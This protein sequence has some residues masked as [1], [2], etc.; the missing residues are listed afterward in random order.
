MFV[1]FLILAVL[2]A[3]MPP[4]DLTVQAQSSEQ[5]TEDISPTQT[6]ENQVFLPFV[7]RGGTS[8]PSA[9]QF[10][11]TA[12]TDGLTI[13]GT[14]FFAVQP[15]AGETISSVSFQAGDIDLG[16]DNTP[17]D[18]FRVFVDASTLPAGPLQ[19]AATATT[20]S[21]QTVTQTVDVTVVADLPNSATVDS[22]GTTLGT[23]SGSTITIP[24]GAVD[25]STTVTLRERTQAE[26]T[27][28]TGIEWENLGV[29]FLGDIQVQSDTPLSRP[30]DIS[31][32]G[33]ANRIQPGQAVVT[34]NLMPDQDGDGVGELVVAN[35]AEVAPNGTIVSSPVDGIN[36][37]SITVGGASLSATQVAQSGISGPPG[38]LLE[39]RGSGFNSVSSSG[40]IAVFQSLI[41]DTVFT[42][43]GVIEPVAE[44]TNEQLFTVL[45]P[46]LPAG[47]ATVTLINQSTGDTTDPLE[48][49]VEPSPA[50][51]QPAS[52]IIDEF[53]AE[54]IALFEALAVDFPEQE[55]VAR[56]LVEQYTQLREQF[57]ELSQDTDPEIQQALED[58]AVV[59]EAQSNQG[60]LY[61]FNRGQLAQADACWQP[62]QRELFEAVQ[63]LNRV[64][65]TIMCE[66][67]GKRF[68][69]RFDVIGKTCGLV[70]TIWLD[71][72]D[73]QA[74]QQPDCTDP[75]TPGPPAPACAPSPNSGRS[76]S[77]SRG[78]GSAPPP[79][80]NG[81]GNI[82]ALPAEDNTDPSQP[83]G[84]I[85][86]GRYTV[87]VV[88]EGGGA[89]LNPFTGS[90]DGGGYFFLPFIP[91]GEP[92]TAIATDGVTG[93]TETFDG[94]GP[95]TGDSV[96]MIFD[97]TSNFDL[98]GDVRLA[99]QPEIALAD[100]EIAVRVREF[101]NRE[102]CLVQ[103]DTDGAYRC[104]L[105]V[106]AAD[107]PPTLTLDYT[108][109][110]A[111]FTITAT[112]QVSSPQLDTY[113]MY[114]RD[115]L[116]DL[117]G[118]IET[119]ARNAFVEDAEDWVTM[120]KATE[121]RHSTTGGNPGGHICADDDTA[122]A[123]DAWYF[124]APGS[125]LEHIPQAYGSIF[126]FDIKTS[127][128]G[129]SDF[130][131]ARDIV[132]VGDGTTLVF[133]TVSNPGTNWTSY[134]V[135]MV[136]DG[137]IN[138]TTD[139]PATQAEM[140]A[141]LAA[142]SDLRIRGDNL[143][144]E[145]TSCLDNVALVA[146]SFAYADFTESTDLILRGSA[147]TNT[148]IN[149]DGKQVIRLTD[150][151]EP[152]EF[153]SGTALLRQLL[154]PLNENVDVSFSTYFSFQITNS[155]GLMDDDGAGG[156][157]LAFIIAPL[158]S[159][160]DQGAGMGYGGIAPSLIVEFDTFGGLDNTFDPD[161]NHVGINLNGNVESEVT[162]GIEPRL[163]NGEVWHAWIDYDDPT[164]R[165]EV[166]VDNAPI[167]PISP[168]LVY[169]TELS[170]VF[171]Q[172]RVSFGFSSGT[173][174]G[175]G[176]H[177]IL[178]WT[179]DYQHIMTSSQA[180]HRWLRGGTYTP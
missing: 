116:V 38:T 160:G 66:L 138:T 100:S 143:F 85:D 176:N 65:S 147:A 24:P 80:G 92:F 156:E 136:A 19:L 149:G 155:G 73:R 29:T 15:V 146:S 58:L 166:R 14:S 177:D 90:N 87:K 41:D 68:P 43:P 134:A 98:I 122:G 103:T 30:V 17:T 1:V 70:T 144:G 127:G 5:P 159:V 123:D 91:E 54:V 89:A 21:G 39:I 117:P 22:D 120:N 178:S 57:Q 104:R 110:G 84:G 59:I 45:I 81:C 107:L 95:A 27:S 108:V 163:N 9:P 47:R 23:A 48:I 114:E 170:S 37:Q 175:Y 152:Q 119:L 99:I 180:E 142:P 26:V 74:A 158:E 50:L 96:Y 153:Q 162:Q 77:V 49:T 165:L 88:P 25:S 139:Q 64:L 128:S 76:A 151:N 11:I 60:A 18:G 94:I 164:N 53:Y 10:T 6:Q 101:D 132:L 157:G 75:D 167:Q 40:N 62:G 118:G 171:G 115:F 63:Q 173:G 121:L 4:A 172:N 97:F 129:D 13:G 44:S 179:L 140:Q 61:Q 79:G 133:E 55:S 20:E 154:V 135:P 102:I 51:S 111:G 16:T 105:N 7:Q 46:P 145:D 112:E 36:V 124:R 34:Y 3:S 2:L 42:V 8:S 78:I 141:V 125:F 56:N 150:I 32:V 69:N 12:P 72:L 106:V 82:A 71:H 131:P 93:R 35:T 137:W 28:E 113:T 31:T 52:V 67:L 33:F 174:S 109:S 148:P 83:D 161:G 126:A 130:D 86:P 168:T 169:T